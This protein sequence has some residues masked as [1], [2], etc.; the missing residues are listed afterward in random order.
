[1][2]VLGI[3]IPVQ[4]P[5]KVEEYPRHNK[6]QGSAK[7]SNPRSPNLVPHYPILKAGYD[8]DPRVTASS[9]L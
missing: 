7:T 2:T 4:G 9:P 1:M 6:I 8:G 5:A 3:V